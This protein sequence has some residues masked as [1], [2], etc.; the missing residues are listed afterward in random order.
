MGWFNLFQAV[1]FIPGTSGQPGL[2]LPLN[3][4]STL[5]LLT[6]FSTRPTAT[7]Q[8]KKESTRIR[9]STRTSTRQKEKMKTCLLLF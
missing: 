7:L 4:N 8:T 3:H 6:L 9:T 2:T 5:L 1:L